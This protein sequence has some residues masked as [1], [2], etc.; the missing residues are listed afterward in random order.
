MKKQKLTIRDFTP[1]IPWCQCE[2]KMTKKQYNDFCYWMNGQTVMEGGVYP[3]DL[4]RF[5]EGGN[6]MIF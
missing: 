2:Q 4:Q 1:L 5:L 3:W 6:A